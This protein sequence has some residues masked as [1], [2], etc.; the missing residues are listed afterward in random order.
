MYRIA[1]NIALQSSRQRP[2]LPLVD[3]VPSPEDPEERFT[4]EE[5]AAVHAALARISSQHREVLVL[6]LSEELSY[7]KIAE[8]VARSVGTG[9][10]R[11]HYGKRSLRSE[12]EARGDT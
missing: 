7:D 9:R 4:P 2:A 6:R 8:A 10:S 3:D 12:M 5:V 1:R 11:I